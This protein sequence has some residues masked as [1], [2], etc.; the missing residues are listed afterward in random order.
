[1]EG[2]MFYLAP[3]SF[4]L[5]SCKSMFKAKFVLFALFSSLAF[6]S[7]LRA[8]YHWQVLLSDPIDTTLYRGF[9]SIS[10]NGENCVATEV[11]YASLGN[12]KLLLGDSSVI[13][14]SHDGGLSWS[15]VAAGIP[16]WKYDSSGKG[17][18]GVIYNISQQVDSLN[19]VVVDD[20]SNEVLTTHDGWKTWNVDS[21][22]GIEDAYTVNFAN[23]SE[24]MIESAYGFYWSTVDSGNH[25]KQEVFDNG[26]AFHSYGDSMFRVFNGPEQIFTTHDNWSTWD[27][28]LIELNGPLADTSFH[29]YSLFFGSGDTLAVEGW[30]WKDSSDYHASVAMAFS[31]DFGTDW[32]ELPVPK[33]N[34]IYFATTLQGSLDWHHMVMAGNDSVGRIVQ[35][36]DGGLQ[37]EC[38]TVPL[39]SGIPYYSITP[40]TVTGSGRVLAGIADDSGFEGSSYLAYLELDPSIVRSQIPSNDSFSVFPNPCTNIL[41]VDN[42]GT[43]ITIADPLGRYY[44]VPR[45]GGTLDVSSLPAGVYFVSDGVSRAKFVK[46]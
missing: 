45:N 3:L 29:A 13:L 31:T 23:P 36:F 41:N 8:Q 33:N 2:L 39:G 44:E 34:G 7:G 6:S 30:R 10:C 24:G 27:T 5:N 12:Q 17:K 43:E 37:W 11:I 35:S 19:V 16:R 26:I 20:E 21:G 46:E 25:W 1:M 42:F 38:D 15:V 18:K 40:F 4:Y 9:P 28:T 14:S 22:S 32:S